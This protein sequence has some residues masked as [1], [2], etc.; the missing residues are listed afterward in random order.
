[1]F[2]V[3]STIYTMLNL[4]SDIF[5]SA[6][7]IVTAPFVL[8]SSYISPPPEAPTPPP[9][10]VVEVVEEAPV[11]DNE[12][13]EDETEEETPEDVADTPPAPEPVE[14]VTDEPTEKPAENEQ[15][16]VDGVLE[17]SKAI[18]AEHEQQQRD[19]AELLDEEE[20]RLEA[21]RIAEKEKEYEQERLAEIARLKN[22]YTDKIHDIDQQ[23]LERT[24]EYYARRDEIQETA[25][26][27]RSATI[28]L[29]NLYDEYKYDIEGL[30]LEKFELSVTYENKIHNL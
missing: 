18:I 5:N 26:S 10:E 6:I 9:Q 20:A 23:I 15:I 13:S 12:D 2:A 7:V 25:G 30:E 1:M 4:V 19:D 3:G 27:S 11:T 24:K 8:V 16:D 28:A 17:K 14:V 21:E 22:E 29:G